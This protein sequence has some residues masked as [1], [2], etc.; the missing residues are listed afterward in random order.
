M[1]CSAVLIAVPSIL[2][3]A[4]SFATLSERALLFGRSLG[5]PSLRLLTSAS[6]SHQ[7]HA[8]S[9]ASAS[10]ICAISTRATHSQ[11]SQH[12]ARLFSVAIRPLLYT[13]TM[14]SSAA[15]MRRRGAYA[16]NAAAAVL[17]SAALASASELQLDEGCAHDGRKPA[18]RWGTAT[19][20]SMLMCCLAPCLQS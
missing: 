14:S 5:A 7:I 4:G 8:H 16:R 15:T 3:P 12:L 19:E 1:L 18:L 13:K 10:H 20:Y 9:S 11:H 6:L 17:C 2:L